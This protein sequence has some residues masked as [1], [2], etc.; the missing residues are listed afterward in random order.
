ME[1]PEVKI[2]TRKPRTENQKLNDIK[3]S[4]RMKLYHEKAKQYNIKPIEIDIPIKPQPEIVIE[5]VII[6]ESKRRGRPTKLIPIQVII[7]P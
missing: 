1:I 4:I 7:E 2:K 3:T 5:N 6:P